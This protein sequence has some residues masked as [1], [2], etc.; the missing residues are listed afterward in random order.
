MVVIVIVIKF[1]VMDIV[2]VKGESMKPTLKNGQFLL[3]EKITKKYNRFDIVVI[4]INGEYY[5]KRVVGL[6]KETIEYKSNQLY[7]NGNIIQENF[8]HGETK[9]VIFFTGEGKIIPEDS[10]IVLG[11]NRTDSIDSR[12]FGVVD[13]RNIIGKIVD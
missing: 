5:V 1:F 7:V 10:Y 8:E 4:K 3:M 6:P 12:G 13:L 9:D 2:I 11:D